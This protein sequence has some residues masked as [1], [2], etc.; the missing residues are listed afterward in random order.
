VRTLYRQLATRKRTPTPQA[1]LVL[2]LAILVAACSRVEGDPT[3]DLSMPTA[4]A[5]VPESPSTTATPTATPTATATTTPTPHVMGEAQPPTLGVPVSTPWPPASDP[6]PAVRD[7]D[8]EALILQTLGE[9][10]ESYGVVVRNLTTGVEALVNPDKVFYAASLYKLPILYEMYNLRE[11]GLL[12]F[13]RQLALTAYYV[14]QDEG[15]LSQLGW[16]EG[17]TLSVRQAVAAMITVSD[18]SSAWMLRD[19]VGWALID[20]DMASIG[21]N[22]TTVDSR[23]LTTTARDMAILLEVMALGQAVNPAASREMVDLLTQQTVRDR[24]AARLP[25]GTR[26]ANKTGNWLGATHDVAIV[27]SPK[28]T[29]VIAILCDRSWESEPIAQLSVAV[30]KYFQTYGGR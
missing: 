9:N 7:P 18:N 12:D 15:T 29:Y 2:I 23:E 4:P 24:I 11:V 28:A 20:A 27:Y 8:L 30:Y 26:V 14:E 1:I 13:D 22:H 21:L 19:L 17:D 10:V 16:E 25:S 6:Q 3:P 5:E